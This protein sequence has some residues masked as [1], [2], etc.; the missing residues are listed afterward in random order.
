M[1]SL[2]TGLHRFFNAMGD[3]AEISPCVPCTGAQNAILSFL[4]IHIVPSHQIHVP[5][6][7]P[8]LVSSI[9]CHTTRSYLWNYVC[10]GDNDSHAEN[11]QSNGCRALF[12]LV[13]ISR[14]DP[15]YQSYQVLW[16]A[17][18][19]T[20]T[21]RKLH[22]RSGVWFWIVIAVATGDAHSAHHNTSPG[23]ALPTPSRSVDPLHAS[24]RFLCID[25]SVICLHLLNPQLEPWYH[26]K[27][28]APLRAVVHAIYTS[29]YDSYAW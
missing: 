19:L 6:D 4:N 15:S 23:I 7:N 20:S 11:L 22:P 3:P 10:A 9:Y 28:R 27:C 1:S 29:C 18:E 21:Q 24:S 25:T 14:R 16:W 13:Q 12:S 2:H 17:P 5:I 26:V 8:S